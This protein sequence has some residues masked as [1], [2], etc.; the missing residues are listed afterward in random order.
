MN[1]FTVALLVVNVCTF[2]TSV[3]FINAAPSAG[4]FQHSPGLS[5]SESIREQKVCTVSQGMGDLW[6]MGIYGDS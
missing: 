4:L 6:G 2:L 1:T 5:K 3:D